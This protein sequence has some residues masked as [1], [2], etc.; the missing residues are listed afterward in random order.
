VIT[1][2]CTCTSAPQTADDLGILR[3][4]PW[5]GHGNPSPTAD[6]RWENATRAVAPFPTRSCPTKPLPQ[7]QPDHDWAPRVCPVLPGV[8]EHPGLR[9]LK[10]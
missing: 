9:D 3:S 7:R 2:R 6:R 8:L 4:T 5:L 1:H 10:G